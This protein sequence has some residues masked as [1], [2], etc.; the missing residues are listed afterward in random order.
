[1]PREATAMTTTPADLRSKTAPATATATAAPSAEEVTIERRLAEA[2]EQLYREQNLH[3]RAINHFEKPRERMFTKSER[4]FVTILHGGLTIKHHRLIEGVFHSF[5]YK[6]QMLPVPDKSDFQAGKEYGNNGQC[7]PTYFTVG[8]LVNF[9]KSKVD[10]GMTHQEVIDS[11]LFITAGACGPCRFGMYEAEFRLALRNSGFDGF[12]VMLFQQTGGLS[13]SDVEAGLDLNPEFF[14]ALVNA[15][16]MGDLLTELTHQ[17]K[18]FEVQAGLA[19]KTLAEGVETVYEAFASHKNNIRQLGKPG[20]M[21]AGVL[22]NKAGLVLPFLDQLTTDHYLASLRTVAARLNEIEVDRLRVK[23]IVKITGEFW[24]QTTEGDGNFKMF[25]FLEREGAEILVE[26]VAT[27][28]CYMLWAAAFHKAERK[29]LKEG[30]P[31]PAPWD[32]KAQVEMWVNHIKMQ[33]GVQVA[34]AL[35]RRDYDK[36]REALGGTCHELVNMDEMMQLAMPYYNPRSQGG[37]GH[38]E[39]AKN[40]YYSTKHIAHMVLSLKPFGCMP[41]TQSDGCQSA[42]TSHYKEMIYLPIETSGEGDI[43]AHSRVQ[44]ALGEARARAKNEFIECLDKTGRTLDEIRAYVD[45]HPEMK[46]PLYHVPHFD[47]VVGTAARFV[48]HVAERMNGAN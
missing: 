26:P 40:I 8:N 3:F 6:S 29:G 14:I 25:D 30:E 48:L 31:A 7:N 11:Y 20:E 33:S 1:V 13:Q 22:G 12:R 28:I 23:P 5:G 36:L 47:G 43:N 24:A 9:L 27:W 4:P 10:E 38:L 15:F 18:P 21:L 37:E 2:R 19:D 44:M 32:I 46:R 35:F 17:V 34:T 42:V 41:S 16:N 45:A 39:V